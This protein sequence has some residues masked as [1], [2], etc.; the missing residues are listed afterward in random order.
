MTRT[1]AFWHPRV[2][3]SP[4]PRATWASRPSRDA[5]GNK[6]RSEGALVMYGPFGLDMT[7][8]L[9]VSRSEENRRLEEKGEALADSPP[10][11][12]YVEVTLAVEG[13][14]RTLLT[15]SQTVKEGQAEKES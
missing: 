5:G 7:A 15:L 13:G 2:R 10:P 4:D 9:K 8:V 14:G 1:R 3:G 6:S 12:T 11:G